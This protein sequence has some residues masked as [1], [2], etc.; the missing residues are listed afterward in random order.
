MEESHPLSCIQMIKD[1]WLSCETN[2]QNHPRCS[3][4]LSGSD[5]IDPNRT[6]L[7]KRCVRVTS[8]FADAVD[9]NEFDIKLRLEETQ[10][11][12]GQYICLSHRWIQPVTQQSPTTESNYN[13]RLSGKGFDQLSPL[14][15]H[16]FRAA[17]KFGVQYVWI[18]SLCIIQDNA[19]DW[20]QE[21]V[22]M[23]RYYQLATFT[24][25]STFSPEDTALF[26][27]YSPPTPDR[28]VRLPYRDK[29][30][31]QRGH[32]YVYPRTRRSL[33]AKKWASH[34]NNSQ[35]LTRGW[36]FQEWLLSRR[37]ICLTPS[38][39]Y[40]QC[41]C[42][43][44]T[45]A[46]NHYSED[47]GWFPPRPE[48]RGFLSIKASLRLN[49]D[50]IHDVYCSWEA[51]VE[52]Y[53]SLSLS[54]PEKDRIAALTCVAGEFAAALGSLGKRAAWS[55]FV[56]GLWTDDIYRGL[57]WIQASP[58]RY[59]RLGSF[60]TWSWASIDAPVRW[61]SRS[62]EEVEILRKLANSGFLGGYHEWLCE[63]AVTN[64]RLK[65]AIFGERHCLPTPSSQLS[66]TPRVVRDAAA[67]IST[68]DPSGSIPP[69]S[70]LNLRGRLQPVF[71]RD[72]YCKW[73]GELEDDA[74]RAEPTTGKQAIPQAPEITTVGT[75]SPKQCKHRI[76]SI[77]GDRPLISG[78]ASLEHP[79][80]QDE[81]LFIPF[82]ASLLPSSSILSPTSV[83]KSPSSI[84]PQALLLALLISTQSTPASAL[85]TGKYRR[86]P[87]F[88][89][90]T[91]EE[92]NVLYLRGCPER[93]RIFNGYERV[94]VGILYGEHVKK[95]FE[96]A[97][98]RKVQLV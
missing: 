17:V 57:L 93:T 98:E 37:I 25:M 62:W 30:G 73:S 19:E 18:D 70:I 68:S 22:R 59:R 74:R 55:T 53:S 21:S 33:L 27:G 85:E 15:V 50:N 7:P 63:S 4:S 34:I 71:I 81:N 39:V 28:I 26:A 1:W 72:H 87:N 29:T 78:W 13:D 10:D 84:K 23:G 14:F 76:V 65:A 90:P 75:L 24:M 89:A 66:T 2:R 43:D 38:G 97:T 67:T 20:T 54:E 88:A 6:P 31:V 41:Q 86:G 96:L 69:R 79:D 16:A 56:T 58:G 3:R 47:V 94:G 12:Y 77:P 46:Q 52:H 49:F 82:P 45:T 42:R 8:V 44:Q 80:F 9:P 83:P 5:I 35:L 51:V 36:I 11:N 64:I 48:C 95:G 40:V 61:P 91:R 32:F 60:P 92:F